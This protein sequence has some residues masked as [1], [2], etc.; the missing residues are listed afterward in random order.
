MTDPDALTSISPPTLQAL[1][2][3]EV[4]TAR[5]TAALE[6]ARG[7]N[8]GPSFTVPVENHWTRTTHAD[9]PNVVDGA[10][11]NSREVSVRSTTF[12]DV[13]VPRDDNPHFRIHELA[14]TVRPLPHQVRWLAQLKTAFASLD[15]K[16]L[17][18]VSGMEI[19]LILLTGSLT[20]I[21]GCLYL[22]LDT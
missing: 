1:P 19:W 5:R 6:K 11:G 7:C 14:Q 8:R 4:A 21:T 13:I 22:S 10:S 9:C 2:P 16:K 15:Q 18:T 17:D 20:R 3:L 12:A